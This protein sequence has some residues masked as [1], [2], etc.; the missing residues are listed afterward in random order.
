MRSAHEFLRIKIDVRRTHASRIE[1][2]AN[3]RFKVRSTVVQRRF[4]TALNRPEAT[5]TNPLRLLSAL[6]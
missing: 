5:F 6:Q 3:A 4:N 1:R 2:R